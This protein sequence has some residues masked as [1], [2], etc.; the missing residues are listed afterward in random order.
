MCKYLDRKLSDI[1]L[2]HKHLIIQD[3]HH[4]RLEKY[5]QVKQMTLEHA[6]FTLIDMHRKGFNVALHISECIAE[7]HTDYVECL[8]QLGEYKDFIR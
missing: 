1:D 6:T 4:Q 3:I 2:L 8:S 5:M 7:D